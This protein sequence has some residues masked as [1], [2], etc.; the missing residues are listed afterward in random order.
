[1]G[2]IV[3]ARDGARRAKS[4]ALRGVVADGGIDHLE[5]ARVGGNVSFSKLCRRL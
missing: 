2:T 4:L 1:M 3:T 5:R